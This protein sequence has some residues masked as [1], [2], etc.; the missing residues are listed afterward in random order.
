MTQGHPRLRGT[1]RLG[2][3]TV[4]VVSPFSLD[5]AR[6]NATT[7]ARLARRLAQ[8]GARTEFVSSQREGA[9]KAALDAKCPDVL[10][11]IHAGH[12]SRALRR[13]GLDDI[14]QRQSSP[15]LVLAIGGNEL[16]EDLGVAPSDDAEGH[17]RRASWALFERADAVLVATEH[18]LREVVARR[19]ERVFLVPRCPEVG[20]G[21]VEGL[22]KAL[23][24]Q[25]PGRTI[26]WCGALRPQKRPEWLL[27]IFHAVRARH[28]TARLL[29]AG[30]AALDGPGRTLEAQLESTEGVLRVAPFLPGPSGSVGTLLAHTDVVLNTSRSEGMSNFL[31]EAMH[32]AVPVVA[33]DCKG[34]RAW[35]DSQGLLFHDEGQGAEALERLLG[36]RRAAEGL[37]LAGRAWLETWSSPTREAD[38]LAAALEAAIEHAGLAHP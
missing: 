33:A 34:T 1:D 31:L 26:A 19:P 11:G 24:A 8:L 20:H 16:Y 6:G 30:P 37:G 36:D 28:A 10:L 38:A 29:V 27:P 21:P 18:Q 23:A 12:L 5:S 13:A 35:I 15:A 4:L 25:S 3:L 2:G 7:A 22:A 17:L 14:P 9:L 32:E